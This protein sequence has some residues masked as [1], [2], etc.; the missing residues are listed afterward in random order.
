MDI[1]HLVQIPP[2][3]FNMMTADLSANPAELF[4]LNRLVTKTFAE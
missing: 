2:F 1:A 4:S 3:L